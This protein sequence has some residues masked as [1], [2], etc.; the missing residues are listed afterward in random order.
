MRDDGRHGAESKCVAH[1]DI[2]TWGKL[3]DEVRQ[4]ITHASAGSGNAVGA[5]YMDDV[6]IDHM[7]ELMT[8]HPAVDTGARGMFGLYM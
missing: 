7:V 4:T 8:S 2:T 3:I 6:D 1:E 5:S